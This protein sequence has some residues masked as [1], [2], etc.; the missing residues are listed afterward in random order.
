MSDGLARFLLALQFMTRLPIRSESYYTDE[1]M[2]ASVRHYPLVGCLIGALMALV[3]VIGIQWWPV[4]VTLALALT[5]GL[6]LTGAFHE[7]G[8]ADTFDGIG[9]GLTPQRS[10]EIMKDSRL[11][12]YGAL[13]LMAVLGTKFVTLLALAGSG[14]GAEALVVTGSS[15]DGSPDGFPVAETLPGA[16]GVWVVAGAL[17]AAH[18]LSRLSSVLVIASSNYVREEGTAKPVSRGIDRE[19]LLVAI[20]IGLAIVICGAFLWPFSALVGALVG[21]GAGHAL[22]RL[23]FE[24][25]LGGY[26]GD[27][28]GAVQQCSE[29]GFHLGLLACL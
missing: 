14:T 10:L 26:T 27:T 23:F 25:K 21:L 5:A 17:I 4:S 18:G 28:L 2:A 1:R 19:S 20:G 24:R 3:W 6:L 13:A 29:L 11:G 12:S 15:S 8:L 7:D 9:G 16:G 22:M